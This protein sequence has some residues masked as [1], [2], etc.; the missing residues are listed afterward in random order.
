MVNN[1]C[2]NLIERRKKVTK[3]TGQRVMDVVHDL[4][5][6]PWANERKSCV[7]IKNQVNAARC[8]HI[9]Y[10]GVQATMHFF[11]DKQPRWARCWSSSL[12]P[13]SV[14]PWK[15]RLSSAYIHITQ[16]R[17][18]WL[19][20]CHGVGQKMDNNPIKGGWDLE[21]AKVETSFFTLM[22]PSLD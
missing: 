13:R 15:L 17:P 16:A 3:I 19:R 2:E 4:V 14:G 1:K 6:D 10:I 9:L 21:I 22:S 11:R 7:L 20:G 18:K 8:L 12:G 5:F